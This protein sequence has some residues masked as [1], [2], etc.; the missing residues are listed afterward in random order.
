MNR[1]RTHNV[2]DVTIVAA[3][4][5]RPR[6]RHDVFGAFAAWAVREAMAAQYPEP[7]AVSF[8]SF[9]G[10]TAFASL[11]KRSVVEKAPRYG[12]RVPAS[13]TCLICGCHDVNI[14]HGVPQSMGGNLERSNLSIG[15]ELC[16]MRIADAMPAIHLDELDA[17]RLIVDLSE[18]AMREYTS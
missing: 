15:C 12:L 9:G 14:C 6:N 1:K 18:K 3:S 11:P 10:P 13:F 2:H 5:W 7:V 16:N 8:G 17:Y 4:Y